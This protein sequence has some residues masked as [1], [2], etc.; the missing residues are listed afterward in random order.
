MADNFI[1]NGIITKDANCFIIAEVGQNHQGNINIAKK[2][3]ELSK[4]GNVLENVKCIIHGFVSMH[5][6]PM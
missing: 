5:V 3:I 2:L 1:S 4:V 6:Q